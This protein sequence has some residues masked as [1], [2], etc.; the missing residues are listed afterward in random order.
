MIHEPAYVHPTVEL[1]TETVVWR[2]ASVGEDSTFGA[3]CVIGSNVY[4]GKRVHAGCD[5]HIQHGSFIPNGTGIGNR[6]FIGSNVTLCDDKYPKVCNFM[7]KAEPPI[8]EHDCSLG[9]GAVILPGITIG[10]GAIIGAGAVVTKSVPAG[11]TWI[12]VPAE[13]TVSHNDER[14]PT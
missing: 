1:G 8:L 7:Y 10:A 12:G 11:E 9:A 14:L 13:A 5:V 3:R 4:I 2:F 6:V